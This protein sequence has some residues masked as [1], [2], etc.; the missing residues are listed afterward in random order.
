M[1]KPQVVNLNQPDREELERWILNPTLSV[2]QLWRAKMLLLADEGKDDTAIA[3]ELSRSRQWCHNIRER[4][5]A[6]GLQALA[7]DRPRSG[8]RKRIDPQRIIT[9]TN[10]PPDTAVDW[11]RASMAK[12][13]GVS[14][15]SVGRIWELEGI[16]PQVAPKKVSYAPHF[17]ERLEAIVGRYLAPPTRA[18]VLCEDMNRRIE[19][20]ARLPLPQGRRRTTS[21]SVALNTLDDTLLSTGQAWHDHGELVRFLQQIDTQLPDN[22]RLYLFIV[23]D[24]KPARLAETVWPVEGPRPDAAFH[25]VNAAWLDA[26][27]RLFRTLTTRP[28]R[29]GMIQSMA[30]LQA[31]ITAHL[32]APKAAPKPFSWTAKVADFHAKDAAR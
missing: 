27:L 23:S 29:Q 3:G 17:A 1:R 8:R 26:V 9:L 19:A 2:R 18:L 10:T 31:A 4:F 7:K 21:L 15:S 22:Q 32:A 11:S 25:V 30:Q 13:A 16:K 6:D 20:L 24:A 14:A 28:L 12:A 5:L